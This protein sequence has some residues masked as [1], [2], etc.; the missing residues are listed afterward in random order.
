MVD[1]TAFYMEKSR[2]FHASLIFV[3]K[4]TVTLEKLGAPHCVSPGAQVNLC[5]LQ[6]GQVG[7][8]IWSFL[9]P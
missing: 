1:S 4:S 5:H 7:R 2:N 3:S 8:R 6:L 9:F